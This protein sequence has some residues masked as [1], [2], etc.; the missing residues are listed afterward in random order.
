MTFAPVR[1]GYDPFKVEE[2][3]KPPPV[4]Y[5]ASIG[6]AGGL[7]AGITGFQPTASP[8]S[9]AKAASPSSISP[10]RAG[11]KVEGSA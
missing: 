2:A 5:S 10:Q 9:P 1:S 6:S 8:V 4:H 11:R 3:A 7:G